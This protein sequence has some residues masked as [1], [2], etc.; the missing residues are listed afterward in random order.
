MTLSRLF[1]DFGDPS[2][3]TLILSDEA[4]EEQR[5]AAFENGYQAGWDDAAKALRQEQAHIPA[6]LA[7]NLGDLSFTYAEAHGDI[8]K[9]LDPLL[10]GVMEQLLPQAA[11]AS[12]G[13]RIAEEILHLARE[14]GGGSCVI[15]VAPGQVDRVAVALPTLAGLDLSVQSDDT[16]GPGQAFLRLAQ[17]ERMIDLD[18]V[19]TAFAQ[20]LATVLATPSEREQHG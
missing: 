3:A 7:R 13:P 4:L 18:A 5:L 10:R 19:Q 12:L 20:T 16:L 11:Q 14:L 8:L 6:E 1:P 15:T 2:T 9:R 17:R